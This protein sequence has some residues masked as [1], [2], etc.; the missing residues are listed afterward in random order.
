[1]GERERERMVVVV[2]VVHRR[3]KNNA[4]SFVVVGFTDAGKKKTSSREEM[5]RV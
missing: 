2:V 5:H 1:M 4:W 3:K